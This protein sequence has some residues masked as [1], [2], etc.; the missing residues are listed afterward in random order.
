VRRTNAELAPAQLIEPHLVLANVQQ[1]RDEGYFFSR[2]LVTP[3]AGSI[4]MPLPPGIGRRDRAL[5]IGISG[6]LEEHCRK[7]HQ[8]VACIREAIRRYMPGERE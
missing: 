2:G 3:G 6:L 1:M 7:E 8:I 5:A 4:A